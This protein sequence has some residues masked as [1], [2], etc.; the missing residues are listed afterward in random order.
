MGASASPASM[1]PSRKLFGENIA[2]TVAQSF[3]KQ[4]SHDEHRG[5]ERKDPEHD[6]NQAQD[7]RKAQE[8]QSIAS[9]HSKE[10]TS[11]PDE[12]AEAPAKK[13]L[14]QSSK[15]LRIEDFNLLKTLGTG[16]RIGN[17][18]T[19]VDWFFCRH[20]CT[21]LAGQVIETAK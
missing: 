15:L 10:E 5:D 19:H 1:S 20:I 6:A 14:G 16:K 18:V 7:M 4:F 2:E 11:S 17:C 3:G 21:S 13:K 12:I 8:Q 9:Q